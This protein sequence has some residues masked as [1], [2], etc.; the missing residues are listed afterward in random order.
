MKAQHVL[1]FPPSLP[2][3]QI[4]RYWVPPLCRSRCWRWGYKMKGTLLVLKKLLFGGVSRCPREETLLEKEGVEGWE[5]SHHSHRVTYAKGVG[6]PVRERGVR[7]A[8]AE[9]M[10][11]DDGPT[12]R[13]PLFCIMYSTF[14]SKRIENKI[15]CWKRGLGRRAGII[16]LSSHCTAG[17][18]RQGPTEWGGKGYFRRHCASLFPHLW[19]GANAYAAACCVYSV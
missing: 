4:T 8:A 18:G 19:N 13:E 14:P 10:F 1:S 2:L 7:S 16:M 9:S 17:T 3:S 6:S 12:S 11:P 15:P 5:E